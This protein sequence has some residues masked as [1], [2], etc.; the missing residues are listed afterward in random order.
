MEQPV[1]KEE[2]NVKIYLAGAETEEQFKAAESV[3]RE[4]GHTVFGAEVLPEG[5][6]K[7]DYVASCKSM[8]DAADMV[9][10]LKGWQENKGACLTVAYCEF[11]NK[12][13]CTEDTC[14]GKR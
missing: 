6:R 2:M 4:R 8:I 1:H 14:D 10:F 7:E 12:M 13:T 11:I 3:L 5:M 9:L